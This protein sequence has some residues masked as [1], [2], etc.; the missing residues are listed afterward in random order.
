ML[1]VNNRA[2]H[3]TMNPTRANSIQ[4]SH[5]NAEQHGSAQQCEDMKTPLLFDKNTS[6]ECFC[7][8]LPCF[9]PKEDPKMLI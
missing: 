3:L 5:Q 1:F 9:S 7:M 4:S 8:C 6:V 2:C